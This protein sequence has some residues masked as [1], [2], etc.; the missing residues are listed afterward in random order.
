MPV[1]AVYQPIPVSRSFRGTEREHVRFNDF[2]RG[3]TGVC[4]VTT[5]QALLCLT[6]QNVTLLVKVE[7]TRPFLYNRKRDLF[8]RSDKLPLLR[9]K[10]HAADRRYS[11]VTINLKL[12]MYRSLSVNSG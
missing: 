11:A 9:R 2:L 7:A 3:K 6:E 12:F 8:E 1:L 10:E 4:L 5:E